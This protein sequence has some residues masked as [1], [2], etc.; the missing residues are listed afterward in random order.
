MWHV[1]M[2]LTQM[3]QSYL[4]HRWGLLAEHALRSP[5]VQYAYIHH[6]ASLSIATGIIDIHSYRCMMYDAHMHV[7]AHHSY[8]SVGALK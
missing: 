7:D 4:Q 2:I 8:F 1:F 5:Q 3:V 6:S